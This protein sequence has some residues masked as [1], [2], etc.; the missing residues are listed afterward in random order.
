MK[1]VCVVGNTASGKSYFA[2]KIGQE[3]GLPVTHLD[4]IYWQ[5]G[6]KRLVREQFLARVHDLIEQPGWVLDGC[7]AE[8]GLGPRFQAADAVVFLEMPTWS[9]VRRAVVRRGD[10]REDLPSGTDDKKLPLGLAI[11][12]LVEII[13]FTILDRPRILSAARRTGTPLIRVRRWADEDQAL[14]ELR[15]LPQHPH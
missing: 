13:L 6:W 9:C 5:P 8:F 12:F 7:F 15:L 2:G 4:Q 10:N 3:F 1:R 11:A 14:A